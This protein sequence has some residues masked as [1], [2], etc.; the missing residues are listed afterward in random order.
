MIGLLF[1]L[2]WGFAFGLILATIT[3][4]IIAIWGEKFIL[5][6]AKARYVTDDEILI[7][8]VKNFCCHIEIPEVKVYWSNVF[9]NNL[10]YTNSYFGKPALVIGR[11][12]YSTFSRNEL[13]SLIY[14]SLLKLKS[15]EAKDRTV[16]GLI[17]LILYSP[18]YILRSIIGHGP[19][20]NILNIF[21]YPAYFMKSKLYE[22]E[23][24]I[25]NFDKEVAKLDGLR[26]D[27]IAALFKVSHLPVC[28]ERSVGGLLMNELNH[29]KNQTSDVINYLLIYHVS[30]EKRVKELQ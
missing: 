27:Y 4:T 17:F 26:K 1:N 7:N 11:N 21:L 13:N 6:F 28:N 2:H 30:V 9:V 24:E 5:I 22:T 10:Y 25:L 8:Q 15:H 3:L 19:T 16:T 20:V 23:A 12:V 29:V 14:A 18:I